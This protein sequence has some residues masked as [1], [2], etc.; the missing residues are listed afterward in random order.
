MLQNTELTEYC[1]AVASVRFP[2]GLDVSK[3]LT[4]LPY[5]MQYPGSTNV[6]SGV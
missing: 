5:A 4:R 2:N 3:L 1:S 6:E